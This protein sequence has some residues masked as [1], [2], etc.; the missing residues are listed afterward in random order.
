MEYVVKI[1]MVKVERGHL[2]VNRN[3]EEID[4]AQQSQFS[5]WVGGCVRACGRAGGRAR[6]WVGG[7]VRAWVRVCAC[8][9]VVIDSIRISK[10]NHLIFDGVELLCSI[11]AFWLYKWLN[12]CVTLYIT[13][14]AGFIYR[15]DRLKPRASTF[16]GPPTKVHN[17]FNTVIGLSHLCCHKVLYF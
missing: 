8:L 5:G 16:R 14:S 15:L 7:C 11:Y 6:A 12:N 9:C 3:F 10:L 2:H 1:P 4:F 17:I 13:H